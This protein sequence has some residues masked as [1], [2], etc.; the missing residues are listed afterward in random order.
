MNMDSAF[1]AREYLGQFAYISENKPSQQIVVMFLTANLQLL[2][3][4]FFISQIS[5]PA[6]RLIYAKIGENSFP[7]FSQMSELTSYKLVGHQFVENVFYKYTKETARIVH[8]GSN[9]FGQSHSTRRPCSAYG[10]QS[11]GCGWLSNSFP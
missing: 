6:S 2:E 7:I 4:K 11:F 1:Y 3:V 10:C 9:Q 8:T 5:Y